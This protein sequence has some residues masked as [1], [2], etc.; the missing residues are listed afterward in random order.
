MPGVTFKV[1]W[2][3]GVHSA[4]PNEHYRPELESLVGRQGWDWDW[5]LTDNDLSENRLTI[6]IRRGKERWAG[7]LSLKWS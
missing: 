3:V 1:K 5:M 4:D 2:P 7:W 6:K